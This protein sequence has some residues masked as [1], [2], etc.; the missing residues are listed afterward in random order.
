MIK[1]KGTEKQIK[2]AEDI[3]KEMINKINIRIERETSEKFK[4][5]HMKAIEILNKIDDA[6]FFIDNREAIPEVTAVIIND[7]RYYI[8]DNVEYKD[9]EKYKVDRPKI[10]KE[11]N[12]NDN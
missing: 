11:G 6:K 9:I 2:W 12:Q 1:L 3:K 4:K 10:K 7:E 8:L 5:R